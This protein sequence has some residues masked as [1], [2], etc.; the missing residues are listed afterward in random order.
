MRLKRG[1]IRRFLL[2]RGGGGRAS[3]ATLEQGDVQWPQIVTL[4]DDLHTTIRL[5]V[6]QFHTDHGGVHYEMS[7]A[8]ERDVRMG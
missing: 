1:I 5:N 8:V 6:D 7:T 4:A 2:Q 3:G